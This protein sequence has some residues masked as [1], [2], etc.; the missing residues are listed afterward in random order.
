MDNNLPQP[1]LIDGPTQE[2]QALS[3]ACQDE[4][5][6]LTEAGMD[7]YEA[8]TVCQGVDL[9]AFAAL[10]V[11]KGLISRVEMLEGMRDARRTVIDKM[12]EEAKNSTREEDFVPTGH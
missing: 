6:R 7:D 1:H 3:D 8:M 11:K 9:A 4:L 10:L 12:I 2:E 5:N